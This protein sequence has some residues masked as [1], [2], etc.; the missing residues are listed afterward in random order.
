METVLSAAFLLKHETD[1]KK[2]FSSLQEA[3]DRAK[4]MGLTRD[5]AAKWIRETPHGCFAFYDEARGE[6]V[7][8]DDWNP[9]DFRSLIQVA[10]TE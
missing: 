9:P 3:Q 4:E 5:K 1:M 8:P 10:Q 2:T 6:P 7:K